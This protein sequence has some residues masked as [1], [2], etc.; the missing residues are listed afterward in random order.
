MNPL[1]NALRP[2]PFERLNTLFKGVSPAAQFP[3]I[4]L[5]VGEPQHAP[6]A[7]ATDA[8]TANLDLL[9]KYPPTKGE[10]SLRESQANWMQRRHIVDLSADTQ[11]LPVNGTREALFAIAQT[12]VDPTTAPLVGCPNPFYQIYEGAA[13]LA[14]GRTVLLDARHENGFLP[15]ADL[16]DTQT[17]RSMSLLYLC[18]PGNPT[19]AVLNRDALQGFIKKAIEHNV[20]L[21]SD[22]CYSEIYPDELNPP[23]GL[24]A[25]CTDMGNHDFTN[26]ISMHSLSK[27]SNLPGLRSGFVAGDATILRE[28]LRYRGYHGSA[29]PPHHQRASQ[30]AWEDEKHVMENR[31]LYREK[32]AAVH[33]ILSPHMELNAPGGGFYFWPRTLIDDEIF[34]RRLYAEHAVVVLPGSYLGRETPNGNP[35]AGRVRMALVP[36]LDDCV[37]AAQRIAR[38]VQ[39]P[40]F[41]AGPEN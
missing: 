36:S 20:V 23:S 37:E 9:A 1:L 21:V 26:C 34:A 6:P 39:S 24:L 33:D 29:M 18:S 15:N 31:A 25:A 11:I 3:L 32:F 12:C 40:Q 4:K 13:L 19:G 2:Y 5:S 27:R 16:L 30:A 38:F 8:L 22:E 28:F 7:V 35:G 17:W 14:G 10:L 41:Q